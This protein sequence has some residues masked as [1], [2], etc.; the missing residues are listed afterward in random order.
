MITALEN[1]P[2][3][4]ELFLKASNAFA[5]LH[6]VLPAE[7]VEMANFDILM[8]GNFAKTG[9]RG[10]GGSTGGGNITVVS[11]SND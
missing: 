7:Q 3:A 4:A 1:D 8:I 11:S 9:Y 2:S 5:G 10:Q 6:Q